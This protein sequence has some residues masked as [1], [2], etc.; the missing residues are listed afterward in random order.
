[1]KVRSSKLKR[2]ISLVEVIVSI[3]IITIISA[4]A[5]SVIIY[6]AKNDQTNL[7]NTQIA[8][9]TKN[10]ID[11]F[12]F[13]SDLEEFV[14]ALEVVDDNYQVTS[15][16]ITLTKENFSLIIQ[17]DFSQNVVWITA[18]DNKG[19]TISSNS[20]QKGLV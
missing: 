11:C 10:T 1:M 4:S 2:G 16:T 3:F 15:D 5:G 7:R 14:S 20:Y 13:A 19:E 8:L 17:Y 9:L 18:L 12:R 6:S